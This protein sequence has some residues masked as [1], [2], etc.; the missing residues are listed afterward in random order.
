MLVR[1]ELEEVED[2][3]DGGEVV[4]GGDALEAAALPVGEGE[5]AAGGVGALEVVQGMPSKASAFG[6]PM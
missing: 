1:G 5:V 4:A 3:G 6:W 2:P